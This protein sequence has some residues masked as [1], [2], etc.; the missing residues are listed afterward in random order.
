MAAKLLALIPPGDIL[1]EDFMNQMI[2]LSTHIATRS[3]A[4]WRQPCSAF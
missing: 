2:V 4:P 3:T 1:Y